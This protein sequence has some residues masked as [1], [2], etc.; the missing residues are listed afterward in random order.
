M[1]QVRCP[2]VF[3]LAVVVLL[4]PAWASDWPRFRG[5][6]GAGV[7]PD[8]PLPSALVPE[9]TGLWSVPFPAGNSSPVVVGGRLFL[10]GHEGDERVTLCLDAA[11]GKEMWRRA[12][13]KARE[14]TFNRLNGPTTPSPATD[15]ENVYAFFPDF[16]LLSYDGEGQERWRTPLGP[17]K[18][19]QGLA[20]SP[21][22]VDGRIAVLVD[23]PEEA[24]LSAF[25]AETGERLWRVERPMSFLGSYATPVVWTPEG[26]ATQIVVVGAVEL[27]G[28]DAATGKRLWWV[29]GLTHHP[30][31]PPFV[32]GDSLYTVEPGEGGGWPDFDGVVAQFD[33]DKDG[34][35]TIAHASED[36]VWTRSFTGMD[37]HI[38]NGDGIL[39][40]EEYAIAS[41][42]M[43][44]GGLARVRLGG[45]GDQSSS[46]I[47]WRHTKGMPSLSGALLYQG[48]LYVV[49]NAIVSTFDPETGELL[50]QERVRRAMG[51]YYA[52]PVAGDG[53]V[54]LAS[55]GGK[56]SVLR[57]G[58]DWEVLSV[59]DLGEPIV[60]SPA[61][62]D[63]RVYVRT[64][65]TLHCFGV[66][67]PEQAAP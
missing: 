11:T 50:R 13:E 10:T 28:Y 64:E 47:A 59:H 39:T 5:P 57:A 31:G 45:E 25:S 23:T 26:Q 54:Y 37:R 61:L 56:V 62:A 34:R 58:R 65:G 22:Y 63:G 2:V 1:K 29:H 7:S 21:V 38:G 53:K 19:I 51:D 43:M 6:H 12:V 32:V 14:E 66:D 9:T 60:A 30:T 42:E 48:V 15:G 40:R 46:A 33:P 18:S 44:G 4:S 67:P 16:G 41:N 24:Y 55:R 8:A 27:T 35:I 20:A 52:S 36:L 3:W 49:R 17:F